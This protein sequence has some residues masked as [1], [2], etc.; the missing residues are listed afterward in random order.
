M[1][2][3]KVTVKLGNMSFS[4]SLFCSLCFEL[5]MMMLILL[6]YFMWLEILGILVVRQTGGLV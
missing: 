3:I 5:P 4:V 2:Q 1:I 6:P